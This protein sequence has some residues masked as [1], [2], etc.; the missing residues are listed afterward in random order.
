[1]PRSKPQPAT[2]AHLDTLGAQLGPRLAQIIT[3]AMIDHAHKSTGHKVTVLAKGIEAFV[4]L[5]GAELQPL[6]APVLRDVVNSPDLDER[7]SGLLSFVTD[8]HGEAASLVRTAVA[9]SGV[10]QSIGTLVSAILSPVI[11]QNLKLIGSGRP[12]PGTLAQLAATGVITSR[13]AEAETE[14]QNLS[15]DWAQRLIENA[16]SYGDLGTVQALFLR[17]Q[18]DRADAEKALRRQGI[19]PELVGRFLDLSEQLIPPAD[20]ADMVVR[21]ILTED[22]AAPIAA[23]Q[24][25]DRTAFNRLVLDNGG[26]LA[27]EEL[28]LLY[29]RG[30]IDTAR[31]VH[32]IK[33]SRVRDEWVDEAIKLRYQPASAAD[34]IRAAVQN[35]L[36]LDQAKVKAGEAGQDPADFDWL[37]RTAGRPPG[38]AEM[39]QLVR[40]GDATVADLEQATRESDLKDKYVP[41]IVKSLRYVPPPRTVVTLLR[42]GA[43]SDAAAAHLLAQEGL[44]PQLVAAEI[45]AAH[46]TRTATARHLG[47][48]TI[49]KLYH[50]RALTEA[51][52]RDMLTSLG[53]TAEDAGFV[54]LVEDLHRDQVNLEHA[55]NHVRSLYIGYRL[56]RDQCTQALAQLS[57]PADSQNQ[58]LPVW[59]LER[60]ANAPQLTHSTITQAAKKGILD[61][62]TAAG[63]LMARGYTAHDAWVLLSVALGGPLSPEP[64]QAGP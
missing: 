12:D 57:I 37:L 15:V 13:T 7:V 39:V 42:E 45:H 14:L 34:A 8:H 59:D 60:A 53:Y 40:R 20:L 54:L 28:L 24:G 64:P 41:L 55:V 58:L 6:L 43:L 47:V 46:R 35:Q 38:I 31:L 30:Q 18:L 10:G 49:V 11:A 19:E 56:S 51:E 23:K 3:D 32:G 4:D 5:V 9:F 61:P 36:P 21:G 1:M 2:S 33:Q 44:D 63:M 16:Y 22:E 17:G 50:D 62:N 48:A 27:L 26:P 52:A 25:Y 29:R